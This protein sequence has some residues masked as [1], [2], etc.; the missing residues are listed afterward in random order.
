MGGGKN[1]SGCEKPRP[2]AQRFDGR[3]LHTELERSVAVSERI[4][5]LSNS[6]DFLPSHNLHS[7]DDKD[8][9]MMVAF[10][11]KGIPA[12]L[13]YPADKYRDI[14]ERMVKCPKKVSL[15]AKHKIEYRLEEYYSKLRSMTMGHNPIIPYGDDD[16]RTFDYLHTNIQHACPYMDDAEVLAKYIAFMLCKGHM[17][18]DDDNGTMAVAEN[19]LQ[20]LLDYYKADM[21]ELAGNVKKVAPNPEGFSPEHIREL[22]MAMATMYGKR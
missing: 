21:M 2:S 4:S 19:M 17:K 1:K 15:P 9:N 14:C 8:P 3:H 22:L 10:Y 11:Y 20:P 6:C 7:A 13:L 5:R 16:K 18:N 12:P